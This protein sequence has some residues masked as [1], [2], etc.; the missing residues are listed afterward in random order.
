[1][2]MRKQYQIFRGRYDSRPKD[3]L[4]STKS[5]TDRRDQ[6]SLR[7]NEHP[8]VSKVDRKIIEKLRDKINSVVTND[9]EAQQL[10]YAAVEA[11]QAESGVAQLRLSETLA[12]MYDVL[13]QRNGNLF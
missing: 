6:R 4:L 11:I 7:A 3:A 9:R 1:M 13:G 10:M 8:A 5:L 12:S 2:T